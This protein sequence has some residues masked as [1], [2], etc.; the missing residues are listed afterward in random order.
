[1]WDCEYCGKEGMT[2]KQI[3]QCWQAHLSTRVIEKYLYT[4]DLR[5]GAIVCQNCYDFLMNKKLDHIRHN[6]KHEEFLKK[7]DMRL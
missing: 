3:Y 2:I 7:E 5:D 4:K 1:M 6:I